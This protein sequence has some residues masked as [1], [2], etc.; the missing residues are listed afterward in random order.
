MAHVQGAGRIRRYKLHQ[1]P[2]VL[3][4]RAAAK[5]TGLRQYGANHARLGIG[6]Q[7]KINKSGTGN[8]DLAHQR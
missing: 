4:E 7:R 1:H 5:I 3:A 2:G 8:A 6:L